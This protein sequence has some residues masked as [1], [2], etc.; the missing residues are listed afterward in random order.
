MKILII[1]LAL[2]LTKIQGQ[3]YEYHPLL[4]YNVLRHARN[5]DD[6]VQEF[7]LTLDDYNDVVVVD[8]GCDDQRFRRCIQS[9]ATDLGITEIPQDSLV[10]VRKL[11]EIVEEQGVEGLKKECRAGTNL[12]RCLDNQYDKCISEDFLKSIGIQDADAKVFLTVKAQMTYQCTTALDTLIKNWDCID[13]VQHEKRQQFERCQSEYARKIQDDPANICKYTQDMVNCM[14]TPF[15]QS[16]LPVVYGVICHSLQTG[17]TT[18]LPQC[19]IICTKGS[20]DIKIKGEGRVDTM[21]TFLARVTLENIPAHQYMAFRRRS[22]PL[23]GPACDDSRF[24]R[25]LN[26]FAKDVG[27]SSFPKR[28]TALASYLNQLIATRRA[29]GFEQVCKS[30]SNMATC[31]GDQMDSCFTAQHL[32]AMGIP[33]LDVVIYREL[34]AGLTSE[35][36]VGYDVIHKNIDCMINCAER[37]QSEFIGCATEF[38]RNIQRDPAHVCDYAQTFL[39]CNTALF[40]QS[41]G[42]DLSSATCSAMRAEFTIPLPTCKNLTCLSEEDVSLIDSTTGFLAGRPASFLVDVIDTLPVSTLRQQTQVPDDDDSDDDDDQDDQEQV[43]DNAPAAKCD[44]KK[45][46]QCAKAY[47]QQLGLKSF[48]ADPA[49]F[50]K[51][52]QAIMEKYGKIGFKK[53]CTSGAKFGKCLGLRQAKVCLTVEHLVELGL[54]KEQAIAYNVILRTLAFE[55][56]KGYRV[57]YN[58][59]DCIAN[60]GKRYNSTFIKCQKDFEKK[61]K[62]DPKNVCKYAQT[63]VNCDVKPYIEKCKP[64]VGRTVCQVFQVIFKPLLP[65]CQIKCKRTEAEDSDEAPGPR[66]GGSLIIQLDEDD[67]ADI[68]A[69]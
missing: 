48:P 18:A 62:Q 47:A 54:K 61:V 58:N 34:R 51:A 13:R 32:E 30:A 69:S 37:H 16:C 49:E 36:G 14:T 59:F 27:L 35:C 12:K 26:Q 8:R 7:V 40:D 44:D 6:G 31:L 4:S 50:S 20:K 21:A 2:F 17:I 55:C 46:G 11:K 41:C 66:N 19:S 15:K 38:E 9:Y 3:Q 42:S 24:K 23:V 63:L 28:A 60:V 25:C 68:I 64:E 1:S 57:I 43:D 39:R 52:L 67:V 56:T 53:I 33:P 45:L 10:F 22:W 65:K 5:H 29:A